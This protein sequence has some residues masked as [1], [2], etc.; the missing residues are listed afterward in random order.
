MYKNEIY[1]DELTGVLNRRYLYLVVDRELTRSK[2]YRNPFSVIVADL[3]NFKLINDTFGH[4]KGDHALVLFADVMKKV[5][6]ESDTIIRYGGDEFV[7]LLPQT[8]LKEAETVAM[9]IL[10]K[11]KNTE[12]SG[13]RLSAS[14]GVASFPEH[15]SSWEEIF[16]AADRALFMSKRLGKGRFSLPENASGTLV[17]PTKELIG[18][19]EESTEVGRLLR[20]G[21]VLHLITGEVGVGKTR[22]VMDTLNA[23]GTQY[24]YTEALG[25]LGRMPYFVMKNFIK[26]LVKDHRA[27]FF[28]S[29]EKLPDALKVELVKLLPDIFKR[30]AGSGSDGDKYMVFEA[31]TGLFTSIFGDAPPVLVFDDVQ[32]I[33]RESAEFLSYVIHMSQTKPVIIGILRTEELEGS[34]IADILEILG[35]MRLYDELRVNP[36]SRQDTHNM[37]NAAL[38]GDVS[39]NLSD[40]VY[41]ESGGNPFFIEEIIRKLYEDK[42]IFEHEGVWELKRDYRIE[43]TRNVGEVVKRKVSTLS[44]EESEILVCAGVYG[45][46]VEPFV[47]SRATGINEGEVFDALD[48]F[49]RLN[50]MKEGDGEKYVFFEGVVRDAILKNLTKGKIRYYH[51]KIADT[52][53]EIHAGNMEN[54]VDEIIYHYDMAGMKEEADKYC[55][56]AGDRSFEIYAYDRAMEY[57]ARVVDR[58][59]NKEDAEKIARNLYYSFRNTGNV[60]LLEKSLS[61][62]EKKFPDLI[63]IISESLGDAYSQKGVYDRAYD[64]FTRGIE[65]VKDE[66]DRTRL[67][68]RRAW[69]IMFTGDIEKAR[70]IAEDALDFYNSKLEEDSIDEVNRTK[71]LKAMPGAYNTIASCYFREGEL[72]KAEEYYKKFLEHLREN[73]AGDEYN[74]AVGLVNIA[75]TCVAMNK[76]DEAIKYLKEAET[77]TLKL[78]SFFLDAMVKVVLG[79]LLV[80]TGELN[81]AKKPLEEGHKKYST[82]NNEMRIVENNLSR[83]KYYLYTKNID[84]ALSVIEESFVITELLQNSEYIAKLYRAKVEVYVEEGEGKKALEIIES[85]SNKHEGWWKRFEKS[86]LVYKAEAYVLLNEYDKAIKIFGKLIQDDENCLRCYLGIAEAMAGLGDFEKAKSYIRKA[87]EKIDNVDDGLYKIS[88]RYKTGGVWLKI[89]EE[90]RA[91]QIFRDLYP[92]LEEKGILLYAYRVS[93]Y[94]I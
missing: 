60:E 13:M 69:P 78:H 55:K 40:A 18:R 85:I 10:E 48:R 24:V 26:N 63:G 37:L 67:K 77:L 64:I 15:G 94:I 32:W 71:V 58:I 82:M 19:R 47:V 46:E 42:A 3:D 72:E 76:V 35:R 75:I 28:I 88:L 86:F 6:R 80:M 54:M 1:T 36:L 83:Y 27:D 21:G 25:T 39:R 73:G 49:V 38:L 11:L 31:V 51:K 4:M 5:L 52:L 57:Y 44:K 79:E 62:M 93:D 29:F 20:E 81:R 68:V 74:Y 65:K 66:I 17:I 59:D 43:P 92:E 8:S 9:R 7:I 84:K 70:N 61:V 45:Q 89:G 41:N 56:M 91:V 23:V 14:M 87:E 16:E 22:L 30:D 53:R 2:R 90:E 33:D 34:S 50:I 12:I